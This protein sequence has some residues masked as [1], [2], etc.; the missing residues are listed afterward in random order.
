MLI[1][2][3]LLLGVLSESLSD[4]SPELLGACLKLRILQLKLECHSLYVLAAFLCVRILLQ[5][6]IGKGQVVPGFGILIVVLDNC[7]KDPYGILELLELNQEST[8]HHAELYGRKI[9]SVVQHQLDS[10][11]E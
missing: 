8:G 1:V 3:V 11:L 5:V 2:T 7:V 6:E 4:G 10:T 9:V